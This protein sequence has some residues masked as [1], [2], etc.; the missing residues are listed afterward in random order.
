M[1]SDGAILYSELIKKLNKK[2]TGRS[3]SFPKGWIY[4]EDIEK[5]IK[6]YK[7]EKE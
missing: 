4:I 3:L 2:V 5:I 6:Q 1:I 7:E